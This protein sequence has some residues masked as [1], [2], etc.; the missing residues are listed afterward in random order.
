M[1]W[2]V[3][4]IQLRFTWEKEHQ[5]RNSLDQIGLRSHASAK[6]LIANQFRRAQRTASGTLHRLVAL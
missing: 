3:N 6:V 1:S 5:I 2:L 4:L